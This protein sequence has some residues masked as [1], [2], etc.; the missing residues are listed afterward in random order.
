MEELPPALQPVESSAETRPPRSEATEVAWEVRAHLLQHQ[1]SDKDSKQAEQ[2]LLK[3]EQGFTKLWELTSPHLTAS[4]RQRTGGDM[5]ATSDILQE[6]YIRVWKSL[7]KFRGDSNVE[8]WLKVIMFNNLKNYYKKASKQTP[9]DIEE[10][11]G[12]ESAAFFSSHTASPETHVEQLD[13]AAL[14][15]EILAKAGITKSQRILIVARHALGM[16]QTELAKLVGKTEAAAKVDLSR[17]LAK[18]RRHALNEA[19]ES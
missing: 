4:L 13:E 2:A 5:E 8:G 14:I 18:V 1:A 7:P 9:M 12:V 15:M 17:G 3:A 6:T 11:P 16:G 19:E 10:M